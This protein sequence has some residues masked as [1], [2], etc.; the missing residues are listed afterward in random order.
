MNKLKDLIKK[1]TIKTITSK[2][3]HR[4]DVAAAYLFGSFPKERVFHDIDILI[5][6]DIQYATPYSDYD[7]K[8]FVA[9]SLQ[10]SSNKIDIL[11]FDLTKANPLILI[12]AVN[13]G[14]LIKNSKPVLLT[15]Q[16]EALS[17]YFL[18]NESY[19]YY[20]NKYLKE[21]YSSD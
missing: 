8:Q 13:D 14:L 7:I 6:F 10:I 12:R 9:E 18:Q 2:L 11:S 19:L 16:L 15:D 20:R 3:D 21:L 17:Q 5:L 1:D 4:D